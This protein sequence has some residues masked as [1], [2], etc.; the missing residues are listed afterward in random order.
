MTPLANYV[1]RGIDVETDRNQSG[2]WEPFA[3]LSTFER[4]SDCSAFLKF[5]P[6]VSSLAGSKWMSVC[7]YGK[8]LCKQF[9]RKQLQAN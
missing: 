6:D 9:T 3:M 7:L 4:R 1:Q 2:Q 5:Y 8:Q